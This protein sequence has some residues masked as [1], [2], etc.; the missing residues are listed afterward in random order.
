MF[1]TLYD[2]SAISQVAGSK[3]NGFSRALVCS[4]NGYID[5]IYAGVY[6]LPE[7]SLAFRD[8]VGI[9]D[10]GRFEMLAT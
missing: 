7:Y 9:L 5:Q 6:I 3:T 4:I 1:H 8:H 2:R 10:E